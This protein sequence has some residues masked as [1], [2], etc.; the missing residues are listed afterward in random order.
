MSRKKVQYLCAKD[1]NQ[2][3]KLYYLIYINITK[4]KD[5]KCVF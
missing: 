2:I 4:T 1:I 3:L 5:W